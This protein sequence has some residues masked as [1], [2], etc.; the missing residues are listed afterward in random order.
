[1]ELSIYICMYIRIYIIKLI[2]NNIF[3]L[4]AV[5][6]QYLSDNLFKLIIETGT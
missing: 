1:M 2:I 6:S 3:T 4:L 5:K